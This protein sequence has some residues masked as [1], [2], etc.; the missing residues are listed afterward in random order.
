MSVVDELMKALEEQRTLNAKL[1]LK[2]HDLEAGEP[3]RRH[4]YAPNH[5]RDPESGRAVGVCVSCHREGVVRVALGKCSACY[6]RS[7][8]AR[9]R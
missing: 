2:V 1:R 6:S 7:Y 4:D 5:A 9:P 8:R 3:R